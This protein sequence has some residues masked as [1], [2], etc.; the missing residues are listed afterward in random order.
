MRIITQTIASVIIILKCV[1]ILN[2]SLT[3]INNADLGKF[4][5][6]YARTRL[7]F[8]YFVDAKPLHLPL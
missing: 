2:V 5:K 4:N 8:G 1:R 3:K 7:K 6:F